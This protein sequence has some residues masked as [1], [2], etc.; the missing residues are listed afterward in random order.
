M[1]ADELIAADAMGLSVLF[2]L[3]GV[4]PAV[5]PMATGAAITVVDVCESATAVMGPFETGERSERVR[6]GD[7]P[8]PNNK[9]QLN[10]GTETITPFYFSLVRN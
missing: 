3:G 7:N 4:V 1:D 9:T 8:E 10:R 2:L 6:R 5:P